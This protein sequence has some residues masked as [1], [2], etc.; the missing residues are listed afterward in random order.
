MRRILSPATILLTL[1]CLTHSASTARAEIVLEARQW[2]P[3]LSGEIRIDGS[4]LI[5]TI[6]LTEDLALQDD[7]AFG[8]RLLIRPSRRTLIRLGWVPLTLSGERVVTRTI[9]FLGRDF[10]ISSLVQ[11][12]LDLEYGRLGFAWQVLSADDGKYRIGPLI[13]A[14]GFRGEATLS[15][16]DLPVPASE[17]ADFETAFASA[18]LIMDL[19]PSERFHVF[20][21]GTILIDDSQ[22]DLVDVEAGVRFF[23]TKLLAIVA[24]YR[25]L[26]IDAEDGTDLLVMNL[27]GVFFGASLHF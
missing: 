26:E 16:P 12:N 7:D 1:V 5:D 22:G 27:E 25:R 9:N 20:A 23:P 8:G 2:S 18:G 15:A 13:E 4:N 17:T 10:N 11:S 21:E 24:G 14:K 3:S 19:E 6:D